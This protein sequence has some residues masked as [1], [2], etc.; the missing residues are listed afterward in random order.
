M[1]GNKST[2]DGIKHKS[3]VSV[4]Q[5]NFTPTKLDETTITFYNNNKVTVVHNIH[6]NLNIDSIVI[7]Q[8]SFTAIYDYCHKGRLNISLFKYLEKSRPSEYTE[9][10]EVTTAFALFDNY[11]NKIDFNGK[12]NVSCNF[13]RGSKVMVYS[14]IYSLFVKQLKVSNILVIDSIKPISN[15]PPPNQE[16]MGAGKDRKAAAEDKEIW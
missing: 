16:S 12:N 6:M 10:S 5:A 13:S 4:W 8:D 2:N 11:N 7:H 15:S 9:L 1:C 3:T 14:T